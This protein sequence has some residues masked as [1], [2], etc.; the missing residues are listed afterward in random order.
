MIKPPRICFS[1]FC[2][3]TYVVWLFLSFLSVFFGGTC[4]VDGSASDIFPPGSQL[5]QQALKR[6]TRLNNHLTQLLLENRTSHG[7]EDKDSVTA[8]N[9]Q[10]DNNHVS[11]L[12]LHVGDGSHFDF[13]QVRD[14]RGSLGSTTSLPGFC[15]CMLHLIVF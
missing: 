5:L 15:G 10:P 6:R 2:D 12:Q 14:R 3:F 4:R 7:H 1:T 11:I 9:I 13:S 8:P